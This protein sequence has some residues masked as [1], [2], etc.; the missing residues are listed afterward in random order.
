MSKTRERLLNDVD[1]IAVLN[2]SR[3]LLQ[4]E[5][6]RQQTLLVDD[7]R[8]PD[9]LRD[10]RPTYIDVAYERLRIEFGGGFYHQ[11]FLVFPSGA[12]PLDNAA[13]QVIEGLWY[14]EGE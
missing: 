2:A 12:E 9:E 11:G 5:D 13:V 4:R 1:H 10:L 6:L 7:A 8:M 3:L 14:F